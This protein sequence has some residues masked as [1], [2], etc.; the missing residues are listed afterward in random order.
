MEAV[1]TSSQTVRAEVAELLG[2]EE[3]ALDPDADLIASGLDSIRMMSLSGRWRKQGI[4]V[5]FAAM[6]ANPTVAAWTRLVGERTAESPGAATQSGD[7]AASAGDPDAPFPL[8]P[9]Q[10]ALWVGRNELTE[11]GGVAA[12]LYV[13]FDGAGVD[14]ERLRTAAAAL[15]A[16]HPMLRVD[17]LGDGM[18][19]ISD[20]DLPVK[21]TDLRHLDVADAE[22]QL[23]VIRHA[24]SHQL[25]EGEV[26]E[27]AL[28]LLP[29][30]RTRLHVDLDMQA[31]DAVSYRNF[32]ADLAALY[33]GAQL[34]ELQYTY[35]Q[36]RSAF[37]AT[38]APTVDED[39]RWWTERIPDLPE[40]PALPLVPRAEQRDPRRGT[41]RWHFLDTDIRDRLFAA[42]RARGITPAMA[43]AASYAGTLARWSTSRHF[44]LNL[45]MFGREPFHPDVDKLVGDFTSSLMLD[46]DFTEAHTPAQRARVMQE[47]LHTSAEHATYSGLSVLRDLSRHHGSPSLAPFVFTSA[48]GLGDL[49]AG[50]VTDQFGTPVWHISQGPQVLLDAQVTPFDGGLLVNWD[51]R[52]DAF[53]PGV[54]D[55]MF[56]Y[57]LAELER[58]AADDAA[59][60]A[61]DPPAVPPAQRAVRDAVN[62]TGA[63]RSDDAL[64]DGFFRTAAHTPDAT[65]V[66]GSTGTLTY[67]ELRE[68]VLAVTGALQVAGI[69]PGDTVAVMGPK[70]ADQV[71]AL[72]AIHAA[73]AVYVPIG[74]DQP[75]D[76]ADSI[77]QTAGVRMALACGD[78]PP[79]FLPALTIA[80]AVR[81]G[82]RVHDVTPATV[83]PDRVAYV[84]FTSG[85]TGAPKGV[86]V[87]HAAAMNT[88]EFINDHF[89]IGPSD[90]SLALSTLEGDLS[91]LDV[92]GMLR[93]GGSLVVV[94]EA[95]RRD[96]DSW[97]RLIAEH[98]VTVLHWM[99]GWL[100]ML[101]EVGGALPSVRVV[102]TGGDWVRTEMVRELRR[103]ATGVRF[104]GLGGATETAI[105]NTICEPGELPR[106]WSAVPFGRPLPNNAC[107]V[108]AADG[109]DCPDWVPGEL[110]VGGRGIARGYRGRPDLTAERF[111]V[112]DGRT[113]YR[114]GDLVRYLPDGQIDFV[115]RADHRVKISGYRIELGEVEAALRRIA[116]V[117]AAVAAVLTAPGDGRGEQLAAI[118]RASSP[119]VTVD[120]LTRRMAELVPPH[121]VPSHIALVEAVPFTVGGKIDRRA[122]T[123]ELTRSMAERANAQAPTY[124]A[125]STALE[126]ALAD[127]VATVLDRDS[128]GADD[129]FFELGGDSVLATQAVARIREWLDSPGVMVTDIFAARRVGALARRLV[130]HESGSDRLEGV[131][132]LYLEVADMNSADVASALHSTSAQASR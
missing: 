23:E 123:A 42:A 124:R 35:R 99:P 75:A 117:E 62:D 52:E 27:L 95:Q 129:D 125:P 98:S 102:P 100:E 54:I 16:R 89:G 39:R 74:A 3:S 66:I 84:L 68:R 2:I 6:A 18:Q 131:A 92:F 61:A 94:D 72:L 37:T 96:P 109:A 31:A 45:P 71:T 49:F 28:T 121:M 104:A 107:R 115:G 63:R 127:I 32:M 101:L 80:E 44:L 11:L 112:H 13:E 64:H 113:W 5:R 7:T 20:R 12:H 69:K 67:A 14:P 93:A 59:W 15:A 91:V 76:R 73:G 22:Q 40:P 8:A 79:T 77:L 4:D 108:V 56:A 33:R 126:R 118:V 110:W 90:R 47:A 46:V 43:F 120:E 36:Y 17:I 65:A 21:V 48:L 86:E 38:P 132:E 24:K 114:T 105:H 111:V 58:L 103:A 119:A 78:E 26:L 106:E 81:V 130:D 30:G 70:C 87:T 128:V 25:L 29:D 88:L 122:V 57:Q 1:V 97:A 41:R 55:A 19:R 82:S 34:P 50:D 51:V 10:H 85:S 116:V 60:D 53:R 83:E 9:I